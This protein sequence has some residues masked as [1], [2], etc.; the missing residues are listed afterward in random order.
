MLINFFKWYVRLYDSD[1]IK[2]IVA[3]I[4]GT[5]ALSSFLIAFVTFLLNFVFKP[6]FNAFL[7]RREKYKERSEKKQERKRPTYTKLA[8][9]VH[10]FDMNVYKLLLTFNLSL[11][12]STRSFLKGTNIE[13]DK[14]VDNTYRNSEKINQLRKEMIEF[15]KNMEEVEDNYKKAL[16]DRKKALENRIRR[17]DEI[18][19]IEEKSLQEIELNDIKARKNKFDEEVQKFENE[20]LLL[21]ND[22]ET[23]HNKFVELGSLLKENRNLI[24]EE[25]EKKLDIFLEHAESFVF[26]LDSIPELKITASQ[27]V[28]AQ[29]EVVRHDAIEFN[30]LL[31]NLLMKDS[32]PLKLSTLIQSEEY[33]SLKVNNQKLLL[34]MRE[35]L[36]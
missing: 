5:I 6:M 33:K 22:L 16:K 9:V 28:I 2:V 27:M 14:L 13:M 1:D 31:N 23:D 32:S 15:F 34:L 35:E 25:P 3:T 8:G 36:K 24:I 11:Y 17:A 20:L 10:I 4:A 29:V 26:S 21:D 18:W 7:K 12:K 19:E 30:L